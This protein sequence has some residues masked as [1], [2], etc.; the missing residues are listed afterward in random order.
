VE[1]DVAEELPK[2]HATLANELRA[3]NFDPRQ[4]TVGYV[5]LGADAANPAGGLPFFSKVNLRKH[6]DRLA[7]MQY[8]VGLIG[9]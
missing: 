8:R 2:W 3:T 7:S 4:W 6:A 9:V 1:A 5:L